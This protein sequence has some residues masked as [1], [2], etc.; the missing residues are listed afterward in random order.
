MLHLRCFLKEEGAHCICDKNCEFEFV[1]YG[2][3]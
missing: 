2:I 3:T 1:G